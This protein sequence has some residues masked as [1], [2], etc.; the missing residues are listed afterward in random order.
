[1]REQTDFTS[2]EPFLPSQIGEMV[3]IFVPYLNPLLEL[4]RTLDWTQGSGR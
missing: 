1:M 4:K 3:S 2:S